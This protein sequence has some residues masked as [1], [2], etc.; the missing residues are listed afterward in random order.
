MQSFPVFEEHP[1]SER[2]RCEQIM[3]IQYSV[4]CTIRECHKVCGFMEGELS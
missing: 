4:Y 3:V 2:E 1:S